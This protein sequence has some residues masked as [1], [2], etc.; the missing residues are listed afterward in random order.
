MF[1]FNEK[2][3]MIDA[4]W[5]DLVQMTVTALI[6]MMGVGVALEGY[7]TRRANWIQRLMFLAA[8]LLLIDPGLMT[9]L[10]GI[11][12]FAVAA[13]WQWLENRRLGGRM[14]P[15]G[16]FYAGMSTDRRVIAFLTEP[17]VMIAKLIKGERG[18]A[19]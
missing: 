10:V 6:G 17:F 1:A 19:A 2:M 15:A 18:V 11:V 12:L 4:H 9:D 8:G 13:L 7:Y 16:D 14:E 5:Y 3:L